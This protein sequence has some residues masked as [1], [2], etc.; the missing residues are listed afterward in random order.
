MGPMTLLSGHWI[1]LPHNTRTNT[2]KRHETTL[3]H[4]KRWME[5]KQMMFELL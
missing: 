4:M 2:E 5:L 1:D 3:K